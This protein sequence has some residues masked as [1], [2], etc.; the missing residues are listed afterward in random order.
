MMSF[1]F[2]DDFFNALQLSENIRREFFQFE[3]GD[4]VVCID[5]FDAKFLELE[6]FNKILFEFSFG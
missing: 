3:G 2:F 5:A 4:K 1:L 6:L